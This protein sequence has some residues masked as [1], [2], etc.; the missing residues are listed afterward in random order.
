M[1]VAGL[2]RTDLAATAP[3]TGFPSLLRVL[4]RTSA[5][6]IYVV[7]QDRRMLGLVTGYSLLKALSPFYVDSNL[8]KALSDDDSLLRHAF[9]SNAHRT[10]SSV[11]ERNVPTLK[12]TDSFVEAETLIRERGGV[13]PVVDDEGR[14]VGEVTRKVILGHMARTLLGDSAAAGPECPRNTDEKA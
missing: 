10:A 12:P 1:Q 3:E 14:L 2:M 8:A 4:A 5:R 6:H 11:M 13:L 9:R 7:D